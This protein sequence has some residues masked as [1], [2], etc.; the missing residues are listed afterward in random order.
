MCLNIKE[1]GVSIMMLNY[2][3][4]CAVSTFMGHAYNMNYRIGVSGEV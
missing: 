1:K 4:D 2:V 3:N